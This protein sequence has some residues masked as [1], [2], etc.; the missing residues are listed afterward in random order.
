MRSAPRWMAGRRRR[1][2]AQR[3]RTPEMLTYRT[4]AAGVPRAARAMAEHL[5]Q[6]TLPPEMAFMAEYYEQ[7]V[8]RPTPAEAARSRYSRLAPDGQ[9]PGGDGLDEL[10]KSEAVRLGESA[11]A[12]DGSALEAGELRLR[13]VAAFIGA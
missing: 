11:L 10:V 2:P 7:G 12:P 4:G 8:T 1:R 5:L 9:L 3:A 13:A 6:Q